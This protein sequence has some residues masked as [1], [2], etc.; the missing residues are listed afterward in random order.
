M[1]PGRD[2]AHAQRHPVDAHVQKTADDA[3]QRE[4][5]QRPEMERQEGPVVSAE[6][7]V[8]AHKYGSSTYSVELANE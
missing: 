6:N 1:R 2:D 4:K 8:I 3:A 5:N 7:R